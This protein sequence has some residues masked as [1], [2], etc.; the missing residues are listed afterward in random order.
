MQ[1]DESYKSTIGKTENEKDNGMVKSVLN[2]AVSQN[3][4]LLSKYLTAKESLK[5]KNVVNIPERDAEVPKHTADFE[6]FEKSKPTKCYNS[7]ATWTTLETEDHNSQT[8]IEDNCTDK[9]KQ[10]EI[11]L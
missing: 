2:F 5:M 8:F 4:I 9:K 6:A 7:V 11:S 10:L 3:K 1:L